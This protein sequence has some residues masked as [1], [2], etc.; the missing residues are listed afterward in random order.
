MV[1]KYVPFV[2]DREKKVIN[3]I[4]IDMKKNAL[5]IFVILIGLTSFKNDV[6]DSKFTYDE[7]ELNSIFLK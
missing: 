5:I 1:L 2:M 6:S 4:T 3:Q 7:Q